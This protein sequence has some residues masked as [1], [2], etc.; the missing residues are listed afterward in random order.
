MQERAMAGTVKKSQNTDFGAK[1]WYEEGRRLT[2]EE[3]HKEAIE[4]F[5]RAIQNNS[6][7]AEAYFARGAS[8]YVIGDYRQA[9]D[10]LDA[11]ALL[12]CQD[13]QF[14]SRYG[15]KTFKENVDD[16]YH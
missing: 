2:R 3:L 5:T 15:T 14:W 11:A 16:E 7:Y 6:T 1:E 10:D 8:H 9:G 13:A 4:A 12:G